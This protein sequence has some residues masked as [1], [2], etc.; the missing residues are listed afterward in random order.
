MSIMMSTPDLQRVIRTVA[1]AASTDTARPV[2][3]GV[4]ITLDVGVLSAVATDSY[5]L[6]KVT[7]AEIFEGQSFKALAP[8]EWLL[9]WARTPFGPLSFTTLTIN[10]ERIELVTSD[11]HHSQRLIEG[12]FPDYQQMLEAEGINDQSTNF[13]PTYIGAAFAAAHEWSD[14]R[15]LRTEA[16]NYRRPCRFVVD[17]PLGRLDLLVMPVYAR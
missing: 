10:G 11:E 16:F 12:V 17:D 6:H 1:P 3:S 4:L 2:L 5:R 15:P 14:S 7:L 9:R 13:N 8:A